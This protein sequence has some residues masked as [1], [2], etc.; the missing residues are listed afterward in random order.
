VRETVLAKTLHAPAFVVYAN[1][2]VFA[3]S[4]D[5]G[6]QLGELLAAGPVAAKQ[7]D[8]A[9]ERVL[10]TLAI[11]CAELRACDVKNQWG[12]V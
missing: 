2:Q 4:L 5:V 1:E 3:H 8:A 6:A 12:V 10:Q 11:R 7:N 9:S